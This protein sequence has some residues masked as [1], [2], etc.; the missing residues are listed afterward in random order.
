MEEDKP[1]SNDNKA[2]TNIEY[3]SFAEHMEAMKKQE[4]SPE[5]RRKILESDVKDLIGLNSRPLLHPER[6]SNIP[7]VEL[8][9]DYDGPRH[10]PTQYE[11]ELQKWEEK[12]LR[13]SLHFPSEVDALQNPAYRDLK[14]RFY[15]IKYTKTYSRFNITM[16]PFLEGIGVYTFMVALR[17]NPKLAQEII[18]DRFASR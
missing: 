10:T 7:L 2:P 4:L 3:P 12:I 5:Q 8:D 13:E 9:L 6:I 16:V 14:S 18:D 15:L 11:I 17:D 1:H